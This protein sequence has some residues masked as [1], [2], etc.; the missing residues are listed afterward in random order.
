MKNRST[1]WLLAVATLMVSEVQSQ[2]KTNFNQNTMTAM[3]PKK[4]LFVVTSASEAGNSENKTGLW[5]EEFTTPFYL[6]TDQG[7][8]VTIASPKGGAAPVDPKS[9]LPEYSTPSVKRFY[10]DPVSEARLNQTIRLETINASDF[11]AVFYPGGHGPMWDL[12][13]DANSIKLI[14]S[15]NKQG[16]IIAL[17]CHA[18]A[19]LENVTGTDGEAFVKGRKVTGYSNSEEIAGKSTGMIPFFLE[20]M[21]K[22]KGASYVKEK[23]WQSFIVVDRNLIT[24]QNPASAEAVASKVLEALSVQR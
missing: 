12:P 8:E 18:P 4:V 6:L 19:V 1:F 2:E 23:D 15:F 13:K 9:K 17:V 3:K 16:K 5:I 22:A 21:L 24:G 10:S 20:D 14:E 7:I 11:D